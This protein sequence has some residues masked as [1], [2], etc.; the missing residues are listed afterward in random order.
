[1]SISGAAKPG[2]R[3]QV[4]PRALADMHMSTAAVKSA[5][6][7]ASASLPKGEISDGGHAIALAAND[8]LDDR[9]R[10]QERHRRVEERLPR[11]S[12]P[13]SRMSSTA[14][15]T[16]TAP[17]GSI[18]IRRSCSTCVK[19]ADANVVQTVDTTLKMLPATRTLDAGGDQGSRAL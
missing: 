9:R 1:M 8:Q 12:F 19:D 16:T 5:V 2:V 17:G 7:R 18:T 10:L 4:N 14:R 3:I 13:T 11:S 6:L 15:S